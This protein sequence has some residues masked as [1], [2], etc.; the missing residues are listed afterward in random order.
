MGLSSSMHVGHMAENKYE[1]IDSTL[2]WEFRVE[3]AELMN[4]DFAIGCD[5]KNDVQCISKYLNKFSMLEVN[6]ELV[7]FKL[8]NA[9]ELNDFLYVFFE[10]EFQA[11]SIEEIRVENQ[12]FWLFDQEFKNRVIIDIG[13]Y[14]KSYLLDSNKS[15]IYLKNR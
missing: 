8:L 4:F 5:S 1:L 11:A 3:S 14:T 10:S 12:C 13:P 6:G 9:Y 7:E 2:T 15:D